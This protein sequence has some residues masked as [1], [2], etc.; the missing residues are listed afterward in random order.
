M[1]KFAEVMLH[2]LACELS[3]YH[4]LLI[5]KQIFH[6]TLLVFVELY[7]VEDIQS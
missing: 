6:S 7:E 5:Q 1:Q 3:I 4:L 2:L